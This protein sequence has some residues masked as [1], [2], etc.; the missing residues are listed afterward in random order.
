MTKNPIA[1]VFNGGAY[2]TYLEWCLTTLVSKT[3]VSIPFNSNG[4][5]HKFP[6][7]HLGDIQ[8]WR[9]YISSDGQ[10]QFVRLHPK[11]KKTDSI[12]ANMTEI[13]KDAQ[14]TIYLY[15]DQETILLNLNNFFFKIW[16]N[17][18]AHI[19]ESEIDPN[20]IYKNWP[21]SS[22]TPID[23]I[24]QWIMREFLSYYLMPAWLDQVEWQHNTSWQHQNS[25]TITISELLF[26]FESS[27]TKIKNF[28]NLEFQMPV[29]NLLPFQE[30]NLQLQRYI[31]H[32]RIC[33]DIINSIK[34]NT[35][36]SWPMLS[37]PSEAW[38]QWKLREIG[39]EIKCH[40]LDLFPTDSVSLRDILYGTNK[41]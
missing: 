31:N 10:G 33:N 7:N 9:Q 11:T 23:Q 28:C 37:L 14:Y 26:D 20:K 30:E 1:I 6:G 38:I 2:G 29:A 34:N 24:P 13:A 22:T 8:G 16:D 36:I 40:G 27:L 19:F 3:N 12:T 21:V 17:W 39:Y 25:T 18:I 15:P 5:S 35:C 41:S 32:D 4:N